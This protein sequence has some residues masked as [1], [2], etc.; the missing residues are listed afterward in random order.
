MNV[1]FSGTV[2]FF[3]VVSSLYADTALLNYSLWPRRP[4]AIAKARAL[5]LQQDLDVALEVLAP[6]VQ[7]RNIG[8][9]EARALVAQINKRRYLSRQNPHASIYTVKSGDHVSRIAQRSQ[10]PLD[11]LYLLNGMIEPSKLQV[12]Q[13]LAVASMELRIDIDVLEQ[14]LQVWDASTLVAVYP[15]QIE[16]AQK[17][18]KGG[19]ST[20]LVSNR[21]SYAD[22][23][24]ISTQSPY[25][26]SADRVLKLSDGAYI[27]GEQKLASAVA[28]Y[29]LSQPDMNELALL[30]REG[31][32]VRLLVKKG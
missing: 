9:K 3:G 14:E 17:L 1:Y 25:Y 12:G 29:Q 8:G 2:I 11:L 18:I 19:E 10:M 15:V 5:I 26:S 27:A 30:V 23:R 4:E 13:K 7:E 21:L 28:V 24:K 32:V 16:S 31:T 20:G 22:G 6:Y